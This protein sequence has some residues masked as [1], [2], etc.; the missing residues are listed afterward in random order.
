MTS[1]A[2][3]SLKSSKIL[4]DENDGKLARINTGKKKVE[5]KNKEDESLD[6]LDDLDD[7]YA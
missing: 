1:K 3:R 7:I 4:D 2:K 6:D 5:I